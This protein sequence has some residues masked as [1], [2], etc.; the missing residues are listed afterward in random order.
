M[1]RSRISTTAARPEPSFRFDPGQCITLTSRSAIK[2]CSASSTQTQWAAHRRGV[3]RPVSARYAR[4][5]MPAIARTTSISSRCSAA[6]VCTSMSC[7]AETA[8]VA[9]SRSRVQ[10]TAKR[11]ASATR[12]RPSAAPCQARWRASASSIA[13]PTGCLR[14]GGAAASL[15]IRHLPTVARR[16]LAA[17][18]SST[19]SVPCTVS[20]VSTLVVPVRRSSC[21]ARRALIRK[22]VSS[23]AA[24][25]GQMRCRNQARSARSSA[26][27]RN[28][29]WQ[30]CTC[31]CTSPGS[32]RQPLTSIDGS[33]SGTSPPT[34]AMTPS[35]MT[36]APSTMSSAS[37]IV[38]SVAPRRAYEDMGTG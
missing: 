34:C 24:S 30:R 33:P 14:R 15:S 20:I 21:T 36:T 37:F 27:P 23:W 12:M 11:G 10:E 6:C 3:A 16:P 7:V 29:V 35:R 22:E 19:T 4:F 25:I 26:A 5:P 28:S 31:V 13:G 1:P 32:T 9:S 38:R 17:S 2:A 18:A 8:A